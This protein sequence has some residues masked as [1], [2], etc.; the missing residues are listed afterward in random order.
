MRLISNGKEQDSVPSEF[1][2]LLISS[3]MQLW[4]VKCRSYALELCLIWSDLLFV[5]MLRFSSAFF[6]QDMKLY[7]DSS[8][9]NL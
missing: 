6:S 3:F 1:K 8:A 4:F 2:L 9:A 5:C 7:W